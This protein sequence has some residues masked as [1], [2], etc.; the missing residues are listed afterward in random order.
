MGNIQEVMMTGGMCGIK[1]WAQRPTAKGQ[2]GDTDLRTLIWQAEPIS[3]ARKALW[4][5]LQVASIVGDVDWLINWI[6]KNPIRLAAASGGEGARGEARGAKV[7]EAT[8]KLILSKG[9]LD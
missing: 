9:R 2:E 3:M 4:G 8:I 7:L 6:N 5:M 1:N